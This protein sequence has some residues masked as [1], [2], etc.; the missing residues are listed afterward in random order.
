MAPIVL[1]L[2]CAPSA[3]L[4]ACRP[5]YSTYVLLQTCA[6]RRMYPTVRLTNL[7]GSPV[8]N[9]LVILLDMPPSSVYGTGNAPWG[10]P[11]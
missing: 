4:A 1:L 5:T 6:L 9:D 11:F 2:H 8:L 7:A 10:P 3:L